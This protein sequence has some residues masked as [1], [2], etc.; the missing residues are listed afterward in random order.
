MSQQ[1][2]QNNRTRTLL[3]YRTSRQH[4][5]THNKH[6]QLRSAPYYSP[7]SR[8]CPDKQGFPRGVTNPV[9]LTYFASSAHMLPHVATF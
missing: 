7:A 3:T 2:E 8:R 6:K 1:P 9:H 5:Q 4:E